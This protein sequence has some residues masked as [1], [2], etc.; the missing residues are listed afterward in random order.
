M[1]E[2]SARIGAAFAAARD[3][4]AHARV[5]R[6]VATKLADRIAALPLPDAP[7]VLEIGSGTGFLTEALLDRG[8]TGEWLV[9]DLAP[10]MV[11]RCRT[12]LGDRA[13]LTFAVLDGECGPRPDAAPFDLICASLA[14]QWFADL[15]AAV[16]RLVQ[17]LAPGGHL[18]FTTLG[19]GTFPEWRAAHLA[20]GLTPGT[21]PFPPASVF[22]AI[23]PE[24]QAAPPLVEYEVER[25]ADARQFLRALK[26]IGAATPRSDHRPL[27][28]GVLRRVMARFEQAGAEAT[29]EVVTCHY[30]SK[31]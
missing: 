27:P 10:G 16:A 1:T 29:Y 13:G 30:R 31:P 7:R 25:H 3:Y 5:Q 23:R 24:H 14:F 18:V 11:A 12:K 26:G 17:W 2:P 9:T 21:P 22:A 20:E 19:A 28:A 8:L 15:E 4:D 6:V